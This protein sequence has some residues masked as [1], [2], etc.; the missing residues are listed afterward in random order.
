VLVVAAPDASSDSIT[1]L[2]NASA[3]VIQVSGIEPALRELGARNVTSL[4]LEGGKTL[5]SA[6]LSAD[7]IDESRT[8]IAPMLLGGSGKDGNPVGRSVA[9]DST[10][11]QV[12]EDVLITARFKEW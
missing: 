7:Q 11:E 1:A 3:E 10:V 5:A 6:F 9:L 2:R 4:F 8:F 12:G